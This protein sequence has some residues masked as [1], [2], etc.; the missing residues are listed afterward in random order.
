M[1][2][3]PGDSVT[4]RDVRGETVYFA[5]PLRVI[6]AEPGRVLLAQR[7]GAVGRVV[8]GYPSDPEMILAQLSASAPEM[9][10]LAWTRTITLSIVD[11]DSVWVPRLFWDAAS[12]VFLG[13][14]VD[15][16]RPVVFGDHVIDTC[17]LELDVVVTPEGQWHYKDEESY[18]H[19]RQVGWVTDSDHDAIEAAKPAVTGAIESRAFPFDGS[20]VDWQWPEGLE[21]AA[22]SERSAS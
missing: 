16:V 12:G 21:P 20:L 13:Y 2:W 15:F 22:L 3:N 4:V 9:V 19:L 17:D 8:R 6:R 14:Y 10:E 7:P 1:P 5:W 11:E 18:G